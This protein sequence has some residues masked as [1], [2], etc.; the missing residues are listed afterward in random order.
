MT[1]PRPSARRGVPTRTQGP[2]RRAALGALAAGMLAG[3]GPTHAQS[4]SGGSAVPGTV[5]APSVTQRTLAPEPWRFAVTPYVWLP[6]I[7][8][9]LDI[10]LPPIGGGEPDAAVDTE[11]GPNRYLSNLS[12]AL[13]LSGEARRGP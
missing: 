2:L 8:A 3:A 10:A 7:N 11:V 13:M 12:F 9:H 4:A 5:S 1:S 6:T